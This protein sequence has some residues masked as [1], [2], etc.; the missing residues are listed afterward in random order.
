VPQVSL[1]VLADGSIEPYLPGSIRFR[2]GRAIRPVCPFLEL[3][4]KVKRGSKEEDAQFE[5]LT[6]GLLKDA[7]LKLA[8]ISFQVVAANLKAQR[9][10]GDK[11]CAFEARALVVANDHS[12][13][14]LRAWSHAQTGDLLVL[15]ERP[16]LLGAFQVIRPVQRSCRFKVGLDTIRVRFTPGRGEVYGPPFATV[17]QTS[18]ARRAHVIVR[19]ENRLLN[20]AASWM[21]Y[22]PATSSHPFPI[23]PDTYDGDSDIDRNNTSWGVVDDTCDVKI[24]VQIA[25]DIGTVS[26]VARVLVGPPDY[27]PDRRPFYSLADDLADRDPG[28]LCKS[29]K[30]ASGPELNLA[31]TD[32]FRR[33]SETASLINLDRARNR[34]LDVNKS[35]GIKNVDGFPRIDDQSMTVDDKIDEKTPLLSEAA[36]EQT[37][38]PGGDGGN[39]QPLLLRSEYARLRH[40]QLAEPE[41]LLRYLKE[42]PDRTRQI[43]RPPFCPTSQLPEKVRLPKP[44]ELRD[45]RVPRSYAFDMRMPPFMRDCDY[46]PLSLTLLQ[47]DLLETLLGASSQIQVPPT[48][49]LQPPKSRQQRTPK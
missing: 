36:A 23:P 4:A 25:A 21:T 35:I 49:Q 38:P 19:P 9:R 34:N 39:E 18:D 40:D 48:P 24:T 47:F 8:Q 42:Y 20:P 28:S 43:I 46:S 41:I 32:L 15:P 22:D 31:V 11:A 30:E 27:A 29:L 16:I 10:T 44:M 17:S 5:P 37:R 33:A 1:E 6:A 14:E 7:D 3:E 2:D 45:A 12:R 13:H 26:G